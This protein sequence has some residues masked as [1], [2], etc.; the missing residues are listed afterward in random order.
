ME[1]LEK[2]LAT[3][4]SIS[5]TFIKLMNQKASYVIGLNL[6]ILPALFVLMVQII[7][8]LSVIGIWLYTFAIFFFI[9]SL[10]FAIM[11]YL[12]TRGYKAFRRFNKNK[13]INKKYPVWALE[14]YKMDYEEF[15]EMNPTGEEYIESL[16]YDAYKLAKIC[17]I[18]FNL[19]EL[20]Y[21]SF[22]SGVFLSIFLILYYFDV[23]LQILK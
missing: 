9:S 3:I 13:R 8:H 19:A 14:L 23:I 21:Y 2:Y 6:I 5:T 7:S 18:K 1:V 4:S 12:P 16:K 10:L 11:I 20:S 17:G 22:F 15:K